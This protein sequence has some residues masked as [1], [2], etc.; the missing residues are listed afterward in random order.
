MKG[1]IAGE[2]RKKSQVVA[3]VTVS[4]SG[5][6]TRVTDLGYRVQHNRC[7]IGVSTLGADGR[8]VT[9]GSLTPED[10]DPDSNTVG[11]L[12]ALAA[13]YLKLK[14]NELKRPNFYVND[15]D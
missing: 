14:K 3:W 4:S 1:S 12:I 6:V 8:L 10:S 2:T 5:D 7:R 9:R 11:E 13:K 15:D